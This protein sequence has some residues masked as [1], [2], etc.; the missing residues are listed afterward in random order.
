MLLFNDKY[1]S[2]PR[3]E[4]LQELLW[5][6][7]SVLGILGLTLLLRVLLDQT[8]TGLSCA[9]GDSVLPRSTPELCSLGTVCKAD[10]L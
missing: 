7:G 9:G 5:I 2:A 6:E 1:N 3:L 4:K 10:N 8:R